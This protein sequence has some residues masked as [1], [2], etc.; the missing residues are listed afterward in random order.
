[1]G[2]L[3]CPFE[4]RR[5][6]CLRPARGHRGPFGLAAVSHAALHCPDTSSA[7]DPAFVVSATASAPQ[8][9]LMAK[10][11]RE[12]TTTVHNQGRVIR[13]SALV[14]RGRYT[15]FAVAAP[16]PAIAAHTL[17]A[18]LHGVNGIVRPQSYDD[19]GERRHE[20]ALLPVSNR[21]S[22]PSS[23]SMLLLQSQPNVTDNLF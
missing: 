21:S 3:H 4:A 5:L 13:F 11:R 10:V 14:L 8:R 20:A 17:T 12:K 15:G 1:M 18:Q 19:G 22:P 23:G 16:G 7:L 9:G 2:Y 6:D